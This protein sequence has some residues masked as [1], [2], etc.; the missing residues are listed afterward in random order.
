M[1]RWVRRRSRLILFLESKSP[2]PFSPPSLFYPRP[3]DHAD[4]PL[5]FPLAY[6]LFFGTWPDKDNRGETK[7][8]VEQVSHHPPVTAYHIQNSSKGVVLHGHSAQK[9]SF[10]GGSI[11]GKLRFIPL[12]E[13]WC[14]KY[15]LLSSIFE[16][17]VKQIGHAILDVKTPEGKMEKYLITL[18]TLQIQGVWM[19][20]PYTELSQTSQIQSST[21]WLANVCH[22]SSF[23]VLPFSLPARIY[24]LISETSQIE[25]KGKGYFSGKAHSF[26]AVMSRNTGGKSH[27]FEGQWDTTSVPKSSIP[28]SLGVLDPNGNFTDV[29]GPKEEVNVKE[30]LAEMEKWESRRLWRVVS[31][32][33]RSGNFDSASKDKTRIEVSGFD[34]YLPFGDDSWY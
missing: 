25:Y 12:R 14:A 11:I 8:I 19:G 16:S 21:G 34:F 13:L 4:N 31:M 26:K 10:S 3:P 7:L 1:R 32:G 15:Y 20:S 5:S 29:R 6:R 2:L 33:I 18:P 30:N 22:L 23:P 9:T 24:I 17:T 27:T 28:G